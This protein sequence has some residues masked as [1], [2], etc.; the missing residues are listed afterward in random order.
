MH[1]L[2][3]LLSCAV[4]WNPR[5]VFLQ[6][7]R[8][9]QQRD[10]FSPLLLGLGV[11]L[12]QST[13]EKAFQRGVLNLPI[14]VPRDNNFPMV[15]YADDKQLFLE[16]SVTQLFALKAILISFALSTGLKVNFTKCC[17]IPMN[18]IDERSLMLASTF[19]CFLRSQHFTYLGLPLG[20]TKPKV[21][22]FY[23]LTD[24]IERR[25]LLFSP[26]VTGLPWLNYVLSFFFHLLYMLALF[27]SYGGGLNRSR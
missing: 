9:V 21:V 16:A 18:M 25:V 23:P 11:D 20:T 26:T 4:K 19:G 12:L 6:S 3:G 10:P 8:W 13:I 22:D 15:Q 27:T 17:M 1:V 24:R 14:T 7:K 5:K 2:F